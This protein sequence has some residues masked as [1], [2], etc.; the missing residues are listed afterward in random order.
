MFRL[1]GKFLYIVSASA[2]CA[3]PAKASGIPKDRNKALAVLRRAAELDINF[4]DTG[5]SYGPHV[6]EELITE[7]LCPYPTG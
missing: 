7:T 6:S 2:Q 4:I 3:L 1:A 5:D